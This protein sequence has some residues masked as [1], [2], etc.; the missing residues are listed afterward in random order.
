MATAPVATPTHTEWDASGNPIIQST[1]APT[2]QHTEWDAE[3]NPIAA[4]GSA[5]QSTA[6]VST[7]PPTP[8]AIQRFGQGLGAPQQLSDY[9]TGPEYLVKH[10]IASMK[11]LYD[12]ANQAEQSLID[13]AY[14]EQHSPGAVNK[15]VGFTHGVESAIP[16]LGPLLARIGDN[17][18]N[19]DIAGALGGLTQLVPAFLGA[20]EETSPLS[21]TGAALRDT[22][23]A[24]IPAKSGALST[25]AKVIGKNRPI[26]ESQVS[27]ALDNFWQ[28]TRQD[29]TDAMKQTR[30]GI[31]GAAGT[32]VAADKIESPAGSIPTDSLLDAIKTA[33]DVHGKAPV[34]DK[35]VQNVL[36]NVIEKKT[37]SLDEAMQL[38]SYLGSAMKDSP[39]HSQA[40]IAQARNAFTQAIDSRVS[41]LDSLYDTD[42]FSKTWNNFNKRYAEFAK[43][44]EGVLQLLKD[45]K[46]GKEFSAI[47]NSK[48]FRSQLNLA[49]AQMRE[50]GLSPE[51]LERWKE[52]SKPLAKII[53][54]DQGFM[55][56]IG[57]AKEHPIVGSAEY[58]A[59]PSRF[60][61]IFRMMGIAKTAEILDRIKAMQTVLDNGLDTSLRVTEKEG[62]PPNPN[63]PL[64]SIPP[65][66]KGGA[67]IGE[68][69]SAKGQTPLNSEN[70]AYRFRP[71][72]ET[73][74]PAKGRPVATTSLEEA[75]KYA[76]AMENQTGKPYEIVKTPITEN[77]ERI[78]GPNQNDWVRFKKPVSEEDVERIEKEKQPPVS[79]ARH[80]EAEASA[81]RLGKEFEEGE[82]QHL[83]TRLKSI[84]RTPGLDPAERKIAQAQLKHLQS[85]GAD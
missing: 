68:Q 26:A 82:R 78:P 57:A 46:N 21:E 12:S 16:M 6:S 73:G 19:G 24:E 34:N 27:N 31:G 74:I 79:S 62:N 13:R 38:R 11:L 32:I 29:L 18:S 40:I 72:G 51:L 41:E 23:V 66:P 45:A 2:P 42:Q 33:E 75:K 61:W 20:P 67:T 60:G 63:E 7:Q 54:D 17:F 69:M 28:D 50:A 64:S 56:M 4:A 55:G 85:E 44:S 30:Q 65:R 84:L 10:P 37:L 14:Q 9:I 39:S 70:S 76:E 15:I 81:A 58:A 43:S 36:E 71:V 53:R 1:A 77:A 3:G 52:I 8:G 49:M 80:A 48:P 47:L 5:S 35:A 25:A 83:I 59:T 22:G